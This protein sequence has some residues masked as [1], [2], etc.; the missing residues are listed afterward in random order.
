[1]FLNA[2]TVKSPFSMSIDTDV[3]FL[4]I[5]TSSIMAALISFLNCQD[6]LQVVL[7]KGHLKWNPNQ[8]SPGSG[9]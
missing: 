3:A 7:V 6:S 9:R 2:N 1:M 4:I 8:M 5:L